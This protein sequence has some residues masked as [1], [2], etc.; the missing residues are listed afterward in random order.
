MT[1][2]PNC[3]E[4]EDPV[5]ERCVIP[6]PQ[7]DEKTTLLAGRYARA[8]SHALKEKQYVVLCNVSAPLAQAITLGAWIAG[9]SVANI[10]PLI[11][12]GHL[13]DVLT[14]LG[15]SLKIGSPNCLELLENKNDWLSP[16]P[17]GAGDNNLF[18]RLQL[19]A[20]KESIVP[21]EW[22]D[23]ECA[24]VVF[25]SGSTGRPKGV[26]HSLGN[27][28]GSAEHTI[29]YYSITSDDRVLSLAPLH[30]SL[31]LLTSNVSL[32]AGCKLL[33]CPKEPTLENILD[34]F[35]NE[36]PTIFITGPI[37]FRHLAMLAGK[38]DDELNSIRIFISSGA[39][40]DRTSRVRLWEKHRVS[41]LDHYGLTET[42]F[43][44]GEH[45]DHYKPELDII[46][47]A[48]PGITVEL[49]EVEGISDSELT[50]GQ[51]RIH[52]PNLFLGY[53]GKSM[54]RKHYL[55]TGDLGTRD[56][57]GNISLK[58]RLDHG[59]KASSTLWIFP[60]AL[61]QLLINRSDVAD[62]CVRSGYDKY[63][64]GVLHAKVV[65]ANPETVDDEWLDALRLDIE[66]QL[67]QDYKDSDIE[68]AS[69]IQRTV[70][71]KIIKDSS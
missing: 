52:S 61:E 30:T 56:E 13:I 12:Q 62:A 59:V 32:M 20:N 50:V 19:P 2:T 64:R 17:D 68:I 66:D 31:G 9:L 8:F 7:G 47:K 58:G 53:L 10:N 36:R 65:P 15:T 11:P 70:L 39:K 71:G 63:D 28:M 44:I 55:D 26:C 42:I 67:G 1:D 4:S 54:A 3:P 29:E 25:T 34:I 46:G 38:L 37:F 60:Q 21:Y 14:Q 69:E 57:A 48:P 23:D 49:T 6:L 51:I 18:D 27:L 5:A 22:N 45:A 40:L 35:R 24:A 33:R 41:V 43:A 16:D